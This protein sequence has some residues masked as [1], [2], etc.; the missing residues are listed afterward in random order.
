MADASTSSCDKVMD[1]KS[2][3]EA[4]ERGE[5][6][7]N[8][9]TVALKFDVE[10][11]WQKR[12]RKAKGKP[13][14]GMGLMD[15]LLEEVV[16]NKIELAG[17]LIDF[18]LRQIGQVMKNKLCRSK[19]TG[20]VNA[21]TIA[22]PWAIF[23]H[24]LV[25]FRGYGG[26]VQTKQK[27]SAIKHYVTIQSMET[28]EKLFSPARFSGESMLA[29]RHFK[30]APSTTPGEKQVSV[31]DGRSIVAITATTPLCLDYNMSKEVVTVSLYV[32]RYTRDNFV[33]DSTLQA[34]MNQNV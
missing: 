21:F 7:W 17:P 29:Y 5:K 33:I 12:V 13:N 23:R 8:S 34:H 26:D 16:G 28:A 31:Y 4:S 24:I 25:L 27:G 30:K 2:N 1:L 11:D 14:Y 10:V 32:Q 18:Y 3:A 20:L 6:F 9:S 19:A 15:A 22:I